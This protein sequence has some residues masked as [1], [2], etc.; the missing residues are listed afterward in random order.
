MKRSKPKL[1]EEK[2]LEPLSDSID[3]EFDTMSAPYV[4]NT[5]RKNKVVIAD[6]DEEDGKGETNETATFK[7]KKE[8]RQG[9]KRK[10]A[11]IIESDEDSDGDDSRTNNVNEENLKECA[12]I[13]NENEVNLIGKDETLKECTKITHQNEVNLIGK[14]ETL[15]ECTK[16]TNENEVNLIAK[17]Y[18]TKKSVKLKISSAKNVS[19]QNIMPLFPFEMEEETGDITETDCDMYCV[20]SQ[21]NNDEI[22]P[23][24]PNHD[25]DNVKLFNS[26]RINIEMVT[27]ARS[28]SNENIEMTE[29]KELVNNEVQVN[30]M[31]EPKVF[32]VFSNE[33]QLNEMKG[34]KKLINNDVQINEIKTEEITPEKSV[35]DTCSQK[36]NSILED[37]IKAM[38]ENILNNFKG[39]ILDCLF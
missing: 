7:E 5:F 19:S 18:D 6:V 11:R 22:S 27:N 37:K 15:K 39:S 10:R 8:I 36:N 21:Q 14:G 28:K 34:S 1:A 33:V 24:S 16:I 30:E 32:K 31:E 25:T 29:S 26:E 35:R 23:I 3:F 13:S 2:P 20:S 9:Y 17:D 12:K 38:E 4:S